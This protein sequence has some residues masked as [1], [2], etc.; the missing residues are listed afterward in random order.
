LQSYVDNVLTD[1]GHDGPLLNVF[2]WEMSRMTKYGSALNSAMRQVVR[3]AFKKA[4]QN[5]DPFIQAPV[6][7][8]TRQASSLGNLFQWERANNGPTD[9][10]LAS[11]S[12]T[13]RYCRTDFSNSNMT[14]K[15]RAALPMPPTRSGTKNHFPCL[16]KQ[17]SRH[18][19]LTVSLVCAT[20]LISACTQ[21][22]IRGGTNARGEAT[23]PTP[24]RLARPFAPDPAVLLSASN[25]SS[26][27]AE[28]VKHRFRISPDG[29]FAAYI[30]RRQDESRVCIQKLPDDDQKTV[31]TPLCNPMVGKIQDLVFLSGQ[32]LAVVSQIR[33]GLVV[34][35]FDTPS[36]ALV[37]PTRIITHLADPESQDAYA[38]ARTAQGIVFVAAAAT[39]GLYRVFTV[40]STGS[41]VRVHGF[42]MR[43]L[44]TERVSEAPGASAAQ[45]EN[46]LIAEADLTT[47]GPTELAEMHP[48]VLEETASVPGA[49]S[50]SPAPPLPAPTLLSPK[51]TQAQVQAP[52]PVTRP[53]YSPNS[54]AAV[55]NENP[56]HQATA[57]APARAPAAYTVAAPRLEHT[58]PNKT[59]QVSTWRQASLVLSPRYL[60]ASEP[61]EDI[62]YLLR[63]EADAS[64]P[65]AAIRTYH[66]L[67]GTAHCVAVIHHPNT[68]P[69]VYAVRGTRAEL[70]L[71][72]RRASV[73]RFVPQVHTKTQTISGLR[74]MADLRINV[75][76]GSGR[77]RLPTVVMLT[78][79]GSRERQSELVRQLNAW[80]IA[81]IRPSF[82]SG[83]NSGRLTYDRDDSLL[84]HSALSYALSEQITA[85]DYVAVISDQPILSSAVPDSMQLVGVFLCVRPNS[86]PK[87]TDEMPLKDPKKAL[88][89][90]PEGAAQAAREGIKPEK[91]PLDTALTWFEYGVTCHDPQ[92][93][94]QRTIELTAAYIAN[95]FSNYFDQ[96]LT[97]IQNRN[98]DLKNGIKQS[99]RAAR[100]AFKNAP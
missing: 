23:P 100:K 71:L 32:R 29:Q 13:L 94:E 80:G 11:A 92:I 69:R 31:R 12:L 72:D 54:M 98:E 7:Y 41:R 42:S 8:F 82:I 59:V 75:P 17:P 99:D 78:T 97:K 52:A 46:N 57:T 85:P 95:R 50:S 83:I 53:K 43:E 4:S 96:R 40:D 84:V 68:G 90:D 88:R 77:L 63:R 26:G 38:F 44:P 35:R 58:P 2:L 9:D 36:G 73:A 48:N 62:R 37:S 45:D 60:Y 93:P 5:F 61:T 22:P 16:S 67:A 24:L 28:A 30:E 49:S 66:C 34:A 79:T 51:P 19:Q 91:L 1:I 74:G 33:N 55:L 18:W 76:L 81:V 47:L 56:I 15:T 89:S 6:S 65:G 64:A 14:S 25:V 27:Q 39:P 3:C 70:V 21:K 86:A 10:S 87:P 20:V